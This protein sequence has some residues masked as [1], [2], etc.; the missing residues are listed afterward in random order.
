MILQNAE[1]V[2]TVNKDVVLI[3]VLQKLRLWYWKGR[4]RPGLVF[5]RF[6]ARDIRRDIEVVDASRISAGVIVARTR[7]WNV[8]YAIRGIEPE[9]PFGDVRELVVKDLWKWAG[10]PWGGPVPDSGDKPAKQRN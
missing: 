7:T 8:L 9:P 6:I 3:A 5:T 1:A 4:Y 10:Q 2:L